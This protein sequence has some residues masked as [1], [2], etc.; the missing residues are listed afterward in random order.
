MTPSTRAL[1]D[2]TLDGQRRTTKPPLAVGVM[3]ALNTLFNLFAFNAVLVV[4]ALPVVTIPVALQ[5]AMVAL[6]RWRADGEDRMVREFLRAFRAQPKRRSTVV[7]GV[8]LVA[9]GLAFVEIRFCAHAGGPAAAICAGLGVAGLV[10]TL[11]GLGY[12]LMLGVRQPGLT[13]TDAWYGA[14]VLVLTNL[15]GASA[16]LVGEFLLIALLELL[17]PALTVLGLPLALLALVRMSAER[18]IRHTEKRVPGAIEFF[19]NLEVK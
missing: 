2:T 1:F 16:V 4:T 13:P 12:L 6:R 8:P 15:F 11:S 10:L 17:D 5:A 3:A 19:K 14:M 9:A 7:V 18:G